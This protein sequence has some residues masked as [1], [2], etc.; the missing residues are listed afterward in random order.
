MG[1]LGVG[2]KIKV[3]AEA[4]YGRMMA[5]QNNL[6]TG[7]EQEMLETGADLANVQGTLCGLMLRPYIMIML[8]K[9]FCHRDQ[10]SFCSSTTEAGN[11]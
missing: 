11:Y 1:D 5:Y 9:S 10:N 8:N 7:N 6:I 3:M 2:K 4:F